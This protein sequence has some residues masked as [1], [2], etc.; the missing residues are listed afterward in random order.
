[1]EDNIRSM[2]A[3]SKAEIESQDFRINVEVKS[4]NHRFLDLNFKIP[5]TYWQL[6]NKLRNIIK[7]Y[8]TR[9]HLDII[10]TKEKLGTSET[11]LEINKSL[12]ESYLSIYEEVFENYLSTSITPATIQEILSKKDV[13]SSKDIV[14]DIKEEDL[15]LEVITNAITCLLQ[16][17]K[18]EGKAL[19]EDL[20][21]R[22]KKVREYKDEIKNYINN[23]EISKAYLERLR[24]RVKKLVENGDIR[25]NEDALVTEVA[26]MADRLDITEELVRLESHFSQAQSI[27]EE[28]PIG[29]KLEFLLQEIS[30]EFNTITSKINDAN[31]QK[32]CVESKAEL[33]KIR[34]QLQNI[35]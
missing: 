15:V 16:M 2:T 1:M 11:K 28:F 5:Q 30:R 9:G 27:L 34:E 18:F 8:I 4:V 25:L 26:L 6:E 31:V 23:E 14:I 13:I 17:K 29:R 21:D 20:K 22:F 35:E 3:F 24:S 19:G 10:I 32:F 7:E 12:L 33:E